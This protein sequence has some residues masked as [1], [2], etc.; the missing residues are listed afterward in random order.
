MKNIWIITLFPSFF[1]VLYKIG[2]VG[3]A[4]RGE[5]GILPNLHFLNPTDFSEKGFKGVDSAPYGGGAGQVLRGDV[6][7]KTLVEGIKNSYPNSVKNI[8]EIL[9]VV[10]L[11]PRGKKFDQNLAWNMMNNFKS[12]EE[13]DIAF[14]CGR[15]E[16]ID[17]RFIEKYVEE[18]LSLGDFILSGGE[19]ALLPILDSIFRLMPGVLRNED[20]SL[21][22]SFNG[23]GLEFPQYTRPK[24][25][26]DKEVPDILLKGNHEN[27]RHWRN[28]E[29]IRVT[30][31]F[32]PDLLEEKK[33]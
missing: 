26:C 12:S 7:E 20:S 14:I 15:Y 22:E 6:L 2:V 25:S 31:E 5:R 21:E 29:R 1:D 19:V 33:K 3:S 9:K 32:R 17:E 30:K 10:Y 18:H 4:L 24:F 16:G 27:I 11:G 8:K 23:D 28:V 13:R